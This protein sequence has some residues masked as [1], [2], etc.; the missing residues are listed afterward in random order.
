MWMNVAHWGVISSVQMPQVSVLDLEWPR[1]WRRRL[2]TVRVEV[3]ILLSIAIGD[4]EL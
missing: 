1:V 3:D 2:G 4:A